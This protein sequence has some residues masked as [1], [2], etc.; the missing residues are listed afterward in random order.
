MDILK[1]KLAPISAAAWEEIDDAARDV[2]RVNLSGRKIVDFD[3][4]HGWEYSAVPL[5]RLKALKHRKG[6]E[7][8]FGIRTIQP[9]VEARV[10]FELDVWE[11]DN[12][13][14]GAED[15]ELE[16]LEEACR[17]LARFEESAIY[18]GLKD[19]GIDG[20]KASSE[21]KPLT[22]SGEARNI[23]TAISSG[24]T[25]MAGAG[26]EGP[27][28]LVCGPELWQNISS[29]DHG[30]PLTR[31]IEQLLGGEIILNPFH[32]DT[33]L[34]STRGGDMKLTVGTDFSIGFNSADAKT[35]SL[36]LTES[37]TFR[38]VDGNAIIPID[39]KKKK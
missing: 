16:P 6:V 29:Q 15:I 13:V 19:A 5:G 31:H 30:Y 35:V 21:H 1:R 14:R 23:L 37:F 39:W 28:R 26:V 20:I 9:L 34:V 7:P 32:E 3:G 17:K 38:V 33:L 10:L 4:P 27:Y 25:Q 2:L 18:E 36:F 12:A 24:I 22:F 11:L 8:E